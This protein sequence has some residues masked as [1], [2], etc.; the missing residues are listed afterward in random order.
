MPMVNGVEVAAVG[1]V[2][3]K[4]GDIQHGCGR[5]SDESVLRHESAFLDWAYSLRTCIPG[6]WTRK[7]S[8][9][10]E[11]RPRDEAWSDVLVSLHCSALERG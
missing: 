11:E 9:V 3:S 7:H 1:H 10:R 5:A 4:V 6:L 8:L 2:V